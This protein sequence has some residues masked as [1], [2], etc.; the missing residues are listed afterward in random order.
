MNLPDDVAQRALDALTRPLRSHELADAVWPERIERPLAAKSRAGHAAGR[1]LIERGLAIQNTDGTY[2]ATTA[3]PPL[4]D[5]Q[6]AE[7]RVEGDQVV[8]VAR[9]SLGR[10]A[11]AAPEQPMDGELVV[12][13]ATGT[14]TRVV[15]Q[16]LGHTQIPAPP[17]QPRPAPP[18]PDNSTLIVENGVVM[19]VTKQVIGSLPV[20]APPPQ[21]MPAPQPPPRRAD[22]WEAFVASK[23]PEMLFVHWALTQL[24]AT[25]DPPERYRKG[26]ALRPLMVS[27]GVA[28]N[29]WLRAYGLPEL[30]MAAMMTPLR[31]PSPAPAW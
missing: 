22:G 30:P 3:A 1:D 11:T 26:E 20:Q 27:L 13:P 2:S 12:D 7:L 5:V 31:P 8:S 28:F 6:P 25:T 10:L 16:V 17:Q 23:Y 14:V 19:R 4:Q 24:V 15:R 9:T 29:P 21:Q 18:Q